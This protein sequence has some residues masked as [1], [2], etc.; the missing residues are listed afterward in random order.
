MPEVY[1]LQDNQ[2]YLSGEQSD[3]NIVYGDSKPIYLS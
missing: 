2:M 1:N 3:T